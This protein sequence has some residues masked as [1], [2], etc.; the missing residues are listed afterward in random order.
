MKRIAVANQKGEDGRSGKENYRGK[1]S[2]TVKRIRDIDPQ[3]DY[4]AKSVKRKRKELV[5]E[6]MDKARNIKRAM[7]ILVPSALYAAI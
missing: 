5:K 2:P 7:R 3:H 4:K 6:T 1:E